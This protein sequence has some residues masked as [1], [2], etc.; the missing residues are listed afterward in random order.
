MA[1]CPIKVNHLPDVIHAKMRGDSIYMLDHYCPD[2][3]MPY[4]VTTL[5]GVSIYTI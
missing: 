5:E 3:T 2:L 1:E 4:L